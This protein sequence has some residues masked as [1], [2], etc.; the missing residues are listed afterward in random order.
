MEDPVLK[1]EKWSTC[2]IFENNALVD[3]VNVESDKRRWP[4]RYRS[5]LVGVNKLADV[6]VFGVVSLI[7]ENKEWLF[8]ISFD[9]VPNDQFVFVTSALRGGVN[10]K[11]VLM[12]IFWK[13][14]VTLFIGSSKRRG[15]S[16]VGGGVASIGIILN[17]G[18]LNA[19]W[20]KWFWID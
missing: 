14:F 2:C 6:V 10:G 11:L 3:D 1:K 9:E 18:G 8:R 7:R 5:I 13:S 19:P 20:K 17:G 4:V 16:G 12:F 15:M